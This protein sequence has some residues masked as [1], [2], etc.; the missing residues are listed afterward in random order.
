[1]PL[2]K[3][4]VTNDRRL[5]GFVING[6]PDIINNTLQF[7]D[8]TKSFIWVPS[9]GGK[10]SMGDLEYLSRIAN[11]ELPTGILKSF[12]NDSTVNS[13]IA[14]VPIGKDWYLM[15]WNVWHS[16][17]VNST[18][19]LEYPTGTPIDESKNIISSSSPKWYFGIVKG[20]KIISNQTISIIKNNSVNNH[21][22]LFILEVD[23]GISPTIP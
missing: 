2:A 15:G 21:V 22:N 7:D 8:T 16:N 23:T 12:E 10:S 6:N 4:Q 17:N 18:I 3:N 13:I 1:M 20:F 5:L 19:T 14:T 9:G 11:N